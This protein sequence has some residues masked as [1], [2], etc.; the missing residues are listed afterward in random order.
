[1]PMSKQN[2]GVHA[3]SIKAEIGGKV[4]ELR[5][6]GVNFRWYRDDGSPTEI[7]RPTEREAARALMFGGIGESQ[8]QRPAIL[9]CC[10][11]WKSP[12]G[13]HCLGCP[14]FVSRTV[15]CACGFQF[16]PGADETTCSTCRSARLSPSEL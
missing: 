3:G 8:S 13:L 4:L 15:V 5:S 14:L 12:S 11:R 2:P 6:E 1:M 9:V 7:A 10:K 16:V